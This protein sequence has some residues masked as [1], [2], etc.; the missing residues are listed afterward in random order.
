MTWIFALLMLMN[1]KPLPMPP[2][3]HIPAYIL[4]VWICPDDNVWSMTTC[5]TDARNPIKI[6]A[7][8]RIILVVGKAKP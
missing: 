1:Q 2:V 8:E 6:T 4:V 3:L 7:G 5:D